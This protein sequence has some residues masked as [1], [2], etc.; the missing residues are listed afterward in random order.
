MH[1]SP[2]STVTTYGR[3]RHGNY[4]RSTLCR[5]AALSLLILSSPSALSESAGGSE[6][7]VEELV[8]TAT[9]TERELMEVPASVTVQNTEELRQ[10]GFVYGTD[11][12]RGVP[13][14]FVR[15]GEGD[16]EEFP[17]ISF[18]GVTGNHGNDTFLALVDGVP[19]VGPDEEVLL[20]EVPYGVVDN[21]E[22]VRGP[23][24][25]L[26][27]RGGIAG[28]VN[29]RTRTV[30]QNSTGLEFSAGNEDY[31][32]LAGHIERDFGRSGI[33]VSAAYEDFEGWRENSAREISNLF[34]K[35]NTM[36][37]EKG[38]L[39][40]WLTLYKREAEVPSVIPTLADGTIVEVGG[41]REAFNGYLP[42]RNDSDGAIAAIRYSHQL[43]DAV[44][45]SLTGQARTY[46]ADV[47]LNF[48]DFFEFDPANSI[49]G[50]N[51][52][53]SENETD[54]FFG[55][56]TI[57][58]ET[59]RHSLI[60]GLSGERA[61]LDEQDMWSG[62]IDPFFT[63]ECGFRF[64][65]ILIDYSTGEVTNDDPDND[66]FVRDQLRTVADTTNTFYG[67]FVQDEIRLT[68]RLTATLGIRYDAFEREVDFSVVGTEPVDQ[69]AEGDTDAFSPKAA[70]SYDYGGGILYFSYGRGFNSNFGPVF[71]WEPDRYARDEEPTTVDSFELGWKGRA[72]SDRL[73][74]EAAAFY[75][76]QKDR[77]I[78]VS[79]PDP[80]GPPTL[81]TT[82][83][84]YS[85]RGFE[86]ALRF[87]LTERTRLVMNYTYLDP[88][89][90]ELIIEGSFGAPDQDFSGVTPQ[91][92]PEHMVFLEASH[93]FGSW[94]QAG[95]TY[96]W[97]DDYYVD[98]SNSVSNGSYDLVGIYGSIKFPGVE[99]LSVDLSVTNLFDE[100][101]YFYFAGSRTMATNVTP[102]TPRLARATVRLRF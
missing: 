87:F 82:G 19:F 2:E 77:R 81:A 79:N 86:G 40:G 61:T 13:G 69:K 25:A 78:F 74:W 80:S 29:Y 71:Q 53:A 22:I 33:L 9:R 94:L 30:Q 43:S 62:E 57:G 91:G 98:L 16:G 66:C 85:S 89:W 42:T 88:E 84:K 23:V 34:V 36:I 75:L 93:Q 76:E 67:A 70:L 44:S 7:V 14:V 95:I 37:G 51:G 59:G 39:A 101:Y 11:E 92:V 4:S 27:G 46:D 5:A 8:V 10:K 21:I 60:A 28:A 55:E 52:F 73:E 83:Q 49:M 3:C 96:E 99:A 50:V 24:S 54:V 47:R 63:G 58:W 12:F 38:E 64:Y 56:A 41:G 15:R 31:Y 17:F 65:A 97:Y 72:V 102:G 1:P 90:D 18:R 20:Y 48:Y 68:D 100:E 45:L 6:Q 35:G 32:R 26:Y